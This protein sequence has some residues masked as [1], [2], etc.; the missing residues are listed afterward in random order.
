MNYRLESTIEKITAPI[1]CV[2]DGQESEY[3]DGSTLYSKVFDKY[4]LIDSISVRGE[5]V[6]VNLKEKKQEQVG[7]VN[8]I[9]E[10]AIF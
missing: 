10:E 7:P 8:W 2:I 9:G 3:P 1:I 4:Y 5:K 6:V